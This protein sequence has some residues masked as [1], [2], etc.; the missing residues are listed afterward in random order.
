MTN[1]MKNAAIN[2]SGHF[3]LYVNENGNGEVLVATSRLVMDLSSD[4][5]YIAGR[6]SEVLT[7]Q[8]IDIYIAK[9]IEA[10]KT[11]AF[12]KGAVGGNYNPKNFQGASWDSISEGGSVT[13]DEV[14]LVNGTVKGS[15]KFTARSLDNSQFAD[16]RGNF[17]LQK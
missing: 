9:K 3:A 6:A 17:N 8:G 10:N 12:E 1:K 2:A 16:V 13:I 14:D 11:Y 4:H 15:F 5:S 7:A